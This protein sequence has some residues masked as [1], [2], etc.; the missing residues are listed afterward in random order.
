MQNAMLPTRRKS[1][2]IIASYLCSL[3]I[4]F[5]HNHTQAFLSVGSSNKIESSQFR[6]EH[7][8]IKTKSFPACGSNSL[9]MRLETLV[10]SRASLG[11]LLPFLTSRRS[12]HLL[13]RSSSPASIKTFF[14]SILN[15]TPCPSPVALIS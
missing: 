3:T 13:S 14:Q 2:R 5:C 8:L 15:A 4:C 10:F 11:S 12:R 9:G 1:G 7:F 6:Y